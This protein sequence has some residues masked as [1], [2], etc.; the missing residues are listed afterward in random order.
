MTDLAP[1]DDHVASS[2]L[3]SA[4]KQT[5]NGADTSTDIPAKDTA[6]NPSKAKR[7]A[8]SQVDSPSASGIPSSDKPTAKSDKGGRKSVSFAP[9]V[10]EVSIPARDS[11]S[12]IPR[13]TPPPSKSSLIPG[14]FDSGA[15]VI[16]IDDD[17]E[18]IGAT[19][20]IPNDESPDDAR[21]RREMLEY[22]LNE[23]GS[24]VA[25]LDLDETYSDDDDDY[26]DDLD[27]DEEG[28][29]NASDISEDEDEHGRTKGRV[30]SN[31][32]RQE[33]ME[34]EARLQA[35][36]I[37]NIGPDP[38]DDDPDIDPNEL[39][40]LVIR[41][42]DEAPVDAQAPKD[43]AKKNVRFAEDIDVQPAKR[44][45][46][47]ST[48]AP[49]ATP[50]SDS[51]TERSTDNP[52]DLP[53]PDAKP[54]KMS[55]FKQAK[56]SSATASSQSPS[57]QS[58]VSHQTAEDKDQVLL[59]KVMERSS[60][61]RSNTAPEVDEFNHELQQR[62]LASEYYR[63]RNNMIRQQG[64]FKASE[65]DIDQPLMEERDGKVKKVSRFKAARLQS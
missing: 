5:S 12:Q 45:S 20:L 61:E 47:Q 17:D 36:M 11:A 32:Y 9:T 22:S 37:E 15:R 29:S 51:I 54:Q 59:D 49:V 26:E 18:I 48:V 38:S 31:E 42:E 62:Q 3:D 24:V 60:T 55:R 16:E 25:E 40:R 44:S 2:G 33:M 7:S 8:L 10:S 34:L 57:S 28:L 14:S 43:K 21:L 56:S 52:K 19:P 4:E 63:M 27:M 46:G 23:V 6:K 53:M 58:T 35:R 65:E 64:G 39:K 50:L 1:N 30:L 13:E 41:H